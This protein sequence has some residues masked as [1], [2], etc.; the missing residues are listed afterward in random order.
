MSI[1]SLVS[2][3]EEGPIG[4]QKMSD[5]KTASGGVIAAILLALAR[6]SQLPP[7]LAIR[8]VKPLNEPTFPRKMSSIP[9]P[10]KQTALGTSAAPWLVSPRPIFLRWDCALAINELMFSS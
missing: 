1:K 6:D 4:S 2:D 10:I 3:S 8:I 5:T 9:I 7:M